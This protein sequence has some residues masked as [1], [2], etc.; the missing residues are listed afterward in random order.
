MGIGPRSMGISIGC[1]A[2]SACDILSS[3][4]TAR[5]A[6]TNTGSYSSGMSPGSIMSRASNCCKICW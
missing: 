3:F 2:P 4:K 1:I 6:P 5:A